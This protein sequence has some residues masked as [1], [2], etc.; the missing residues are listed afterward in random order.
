MA[1]HSTKEGGPVKRKVIMVELKV[2]MENT[3]P[4]MFFG[5]KKAIFEYYGKALGI[6]YN[7]SLTINFNKNGGFENSKCRIYQDGVLTDHCPEIV[8]RRAREGREEI[9]NR[10]NFDWVDD[11]V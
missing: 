9:V 5:S 2:P 6:S 8:E 1:R 11:I 3:P 4:I 10:Q 7:T